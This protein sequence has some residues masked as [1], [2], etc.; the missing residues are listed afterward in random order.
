M[1]LLLYFHLIVEEAKDGLICQKSE[2][3]MAKPSFK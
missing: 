1:K 3:V 2:L